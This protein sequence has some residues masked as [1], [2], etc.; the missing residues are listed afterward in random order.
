MKRL[1]VSCL[2]LAM[3]GAYLKADVLCVTTRDAD[4]PTFFELS[5]RPK[6]IFEG[7]SVIIRTNDK[8]LEYPL[9]NYVKFTFT[10]GTDIRTIK[11]DG[12][13]LRIENNVISLSGLE[14]SNYIALYDLTGKVVASGKT[15]QEGLW[16][17][18]VTTGSYIIKIGSRTI[19]IFIK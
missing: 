8:S 7:E 16:E 1:F 13:K 5:G 19:N 4:S 11:A 15:D 14:K 17:S 12:L 6:L 10:E 18:P 9:S 3:G 2:L